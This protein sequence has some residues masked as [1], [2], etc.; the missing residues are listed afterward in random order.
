[1]HTPDD[2]ILILDFGS[3][4][5]QLIARRIREVG[6]YCE[7]VPFAKGG[8]A[9]TRMQPKGVILSGS[10]ANISDENGPRI[11]DV[12]LAA[13]VPLLGICYGEQSLCYQLGGAVVASDHR[14]FGRAEID[15]VDDCAFF[16]G[17]WAKGDRPTV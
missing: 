17:V 10:P 5:T 3:Q 1:M 2:S 13:D 12:V 8:E 14:E 15:I 11:P 9:Y 7:I 16:A 6:V 4:V